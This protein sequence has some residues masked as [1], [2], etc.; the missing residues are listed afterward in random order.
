MTDLHCHILPAIDDGAKN[1]DISM[2]LLRMQNDSGIT[3]IVSTPHFNPEHQNLDEFIAKR[4][5]SARRL[6]DA[7]FH[8]ELPMRLK[9]GAEVR[10]SPTLLEL[11]SHPLCF[12]KTSVMLLEMPMNLRPQWDV[13]VVYQLAI[14]GIIPLI[15]HI[16]RYP[17]IQKN[18]NIALKWVEAGAFL[19][20]NASSITDGW[21]HRNLVYKLL[22]HGLVHVIASDTH[23]PERRPPQLGR[24]MHMLAKKFGNEICKKL[25]CNAQLLFNGQA[26]DVE[27]PTSFSERAR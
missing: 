15:A 26:P 4:F 11:D 9:F 1:V 19:Q 7:V 13:N 23:S 10:I 8:S 12:Q 27:L 22:K 14:M 18:P 16:E 2:R 17:Y 5:N 3:D 20:V 6:A 25:E 24:A 21:V